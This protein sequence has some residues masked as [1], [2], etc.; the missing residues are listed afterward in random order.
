MAMAL[1]IAHG[2]TGCSEIDGNGVGAG[3]FPARLGLSTAMG[4]TVHVLFHVV[5]GDKKLKAEVSDLRVVL[6]IGN[7]QPVFP[8]S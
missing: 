7:L 6:K 1:F 8:G 4:L 3:L 5:V 2:R